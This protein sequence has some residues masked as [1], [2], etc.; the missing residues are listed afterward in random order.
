MKLSLL[1]IKLDKNLKKVSILI[2]F[3]N[4]TCIFSD[5]KFDCK[6]DCK[7]VLNFICEG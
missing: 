5:C 7:G 4:I 2:H 1:S 3:I 6:G